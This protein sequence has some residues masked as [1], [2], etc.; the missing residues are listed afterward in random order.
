MRIPAIVTVH[1]NVFEI[2][3]HKVQTTLKIDIS[4]SRNPCNNHRSYMKNQFMSLVLFKKLGC[5]MFVQISVFPPPQ[6]S[7]IQKLHCYSTKL[8]TMQLAMLVWS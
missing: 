5:T 1:G 6:P 8:E 7:S 2:R 3:Y 4:F